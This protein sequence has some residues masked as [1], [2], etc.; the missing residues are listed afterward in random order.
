MVLSYELPGPLS[1]RRLNRLFFAFRSI[2]PFPFETIVG[3][4][5]SFCCFMQKEKETDVL[6]PFLFG[7]YSHNIPCFHVHFEQKS[8]LGGWLFNENAK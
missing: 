3:E 8:Q 2:Y 4:L 6:F 1:I 5:H 7:Y